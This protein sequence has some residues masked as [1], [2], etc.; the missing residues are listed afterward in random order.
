M[1]TE[2]HK[3]K[4]SNPSVDSKTVQTP[5]EEDPIQVLEKKTSP[6]EA[7]NIRE[8]R[9]SDA[10]ILTD[11]R[12]YHARLLNIPKYAKETLLLQQARK[13]KAKT[14]HIFNNHNEKQKG[15]V[16]LE[17]LSKK[18]KEFT[19][20]HGINYHN[21]RLIWEEKTIEKKESF[22]QQ[23]LKFKSEVVENNMRYE[24]ERQEVS[25]ESNM[26]VRAE[27]NKIK[28]KN[29]V[30]EYTEGDRKKKAK[31][32]LVEKVE[33]LC[34]KYIEEL[35]ASLVQEI[36]SQVK[37][38]EN[39]LQDKGKIDDFLELKLQ[40]LVDF[41]T[42][43]KFNL[44]GIV[45]M[46]IDSRQGKF[47]KINRSRYLD[48]WTNVEKDKKK[49]SGVKVLIDKKWA[50]HITKVQKRNP[51]VL[52]TIRTSLQK[53]VINAIATRKRDTYYILETLLPKRDQKYMDE[54]KNQDKNRSHLGR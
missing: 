2:I 52:R 19:L 53:E 27:S 33:N 40:E 22:K 44:L 46:N 34:S 15:S 20:K 30:K 32:Q 12:V 36:I 37:Q 24:K 48:F 49:R 26:I 29:K 54:W 47:I 18:N 21:Q 6:L 8:R 9:K 11:R 38:E 41:G 28:E 5:K 7:S 4:S 1:E 13:I 3:A 50:A 45:K 25:R 14:V 17:F 10:P 39:L 42:R 31:I 43:E 23:D 16:V 51:I 35:K